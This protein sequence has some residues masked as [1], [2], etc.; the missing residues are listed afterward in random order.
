[1]GLDGVGGGGRAKEDEAEGGA[2][3]C[4]E[5]A[6]VQAGEDWAFFFVDLFPVGALAGL[7]LFLLAGKREEGPLQGYFIA[8]LDGSAAG[9]GEEG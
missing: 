7:L 8:V 4:G 1:M 9:A 2:N 6:W 5:G 3:G